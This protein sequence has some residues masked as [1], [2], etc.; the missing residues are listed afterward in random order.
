MSRSSVARLFALLTLSS[1]AYGVPAFARP[2]APKTVAP[3]P[4]ES[5]D[6]EAERLRQKGGLIK[7]N[8]I[9]PGQAERHGRAEILISAPVD[10]VERH[11]RA[12]GQYKDLAPGKFKTSRIVGKEGDATDVYMQI[13]IMKGFVTLWQIMRF[14]STTEVSPG[15]TAIEGTYRQGNLKNAHALFVLRKVDDNTTILR[16]DMLISLAIP[17]PQELVDEELRDYAGDALLGMREKA[18]AAARAAQPVRDK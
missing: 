18:E 3:K 4:T 17:A 12:F 5:A 16:L 1:L 9:P 6:V 8:I 10:I 14:S 15:V 11:V 13:Q 7:S 2:C